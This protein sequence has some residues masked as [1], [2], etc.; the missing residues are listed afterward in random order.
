[1]IHDED[2]EPEE[3]EDVSGYCAYCYSWDTDGIRAEI[4]N[5]AGCKPEEVTLFA[6]TGA[7]F[8]DV[9]SGV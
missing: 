7:G 6:Y 2:T 8:H 1:M 3:A 9:Y 5:I 4:A